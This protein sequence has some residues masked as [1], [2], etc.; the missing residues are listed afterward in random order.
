MAQASLEASDSTGDTPITVAAKQGHVECLQILV[1]EARGSEEEE[2]SLGEG[3]REAKGKYLV[4]TATSLNHPANS[5]A[6]NIRSPENHRRCSFSS[7]ALCS[8]L[9]S[10]LGG[11]LCGCDRVANR[12]RLVGLVHRAMSVIFG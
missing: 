8:L 12:V 1:R 7:K 6:T 11:M 3:Y 2:P 10:E 9:E 4:D 5:S